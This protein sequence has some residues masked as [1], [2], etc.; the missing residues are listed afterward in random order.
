LEA[1]LQRQKIP[2]TF[3]ALELDRP[4]GA[5]SLTLEDMET[6]KDLSPWL[7]GVFVLPEFRARGIASNLVKAV[8]EKARNLEV[9]E[10]YL[11]SI[12]AI[13]LYEKLGWQEFDRVIHKG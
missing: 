9:R 10:L 4:V 12:R 5:V 2:L 7:T 11:Y 3:V 8:E 13:G 6:R 1:H